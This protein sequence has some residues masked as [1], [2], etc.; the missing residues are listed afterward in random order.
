MQD[1]PAGKTGRRSVVESIW[2]DCA[3][4]NVIPM[5]AHGD[6]S[7]RGIDETMFQLKYMYIINCIYIY[8]R[9]YILCIV[10]IIN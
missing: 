5:K 9:S 3:V 8:Y 2:H 10:Y 4:A 6:S 7:G 1:S